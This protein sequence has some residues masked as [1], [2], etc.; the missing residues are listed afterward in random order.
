MFI[1]PLAALAALT[2][3]AGWV[4]GLAVVPYYLAAKALSLV[5]KTSRR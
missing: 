5:A 1:I 3:I 4:T 2:T